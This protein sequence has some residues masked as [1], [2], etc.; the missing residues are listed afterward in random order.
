MSDRSAD[1]GVVVTGDG[2]T[3]TLTFG[4]S[5]V[6]LPLLRKQFRPVERRPRPAPGEPPRELD[7]LDPETGRL[8]LIGRR[9]VLAELQT[10]LDDEVDISVHAL[11]GPAG[12]GKTRLAMELCQRIDRDPGGNDTWIAGFLSADDLRA[13]VDIFASNS[14]EWAQPTLLVIDNAA[15]CQQG[16]ALWLD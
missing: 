9:D 3:V 1:A 11:I 4:R 6:S 10:W 13:V 14:F 12:S 2:N 15:Q 8:P 7:L 16:L 5:G